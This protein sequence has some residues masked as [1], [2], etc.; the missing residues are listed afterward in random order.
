MW[1]D[2]GWRCL[3]VIGVVAGEILPV[4]LKEPCESR[5]GVDMVAMEVVGAILGVKGADLAAA[6]CAVALRTGMSG[7]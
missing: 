6:F 3:F 5:A 7:R 2:S 4:L 1:H